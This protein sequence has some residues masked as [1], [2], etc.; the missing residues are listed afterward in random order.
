[1][2]NSGVIV[3]NCKETIDAVHYKATN[4]NQNIEKLNKWVVGVE[5]II[6]Y[7]SKEVEDFVTQYFSKITT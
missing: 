2:S 7:P 3:K 4:C 5:D 1:M 6:N